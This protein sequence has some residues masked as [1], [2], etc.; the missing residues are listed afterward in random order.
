[1][2]PLLR[3]WTMTGRMVNPSLKARGF[4]FENIWEPIFK[5]LNMRRIKE[6][7]NAD[8]MYNRCESFVVKDMLVQYNHPAT[9]SAGLIRKIL[10]SK[11]F[12][13][14]KQVQHPHQGWLRSDWAVHQARRCWGQ[15]LTWIVV[16]KF[17]FRYSCVPCQSPV[18]G[19]SLKTRHR[20]K[21]A[22]S[23]YWDI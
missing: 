9:G 2:V 6:R 1:M 15:A 5:D 7:T 12:T 14:C 3:G 19:H 11:N 13:F 4:H 21:G 22:C 18:Y 10:E 20:G 23:K 8:K 16:I 17:M